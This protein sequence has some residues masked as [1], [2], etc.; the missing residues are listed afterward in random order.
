MK[1]SKRKQA[2]QA[3]PHQDFIRKFLLD[4]FPHALGTDS[5]HLNHPAAVPAL[6]DKLKARTAKLERPA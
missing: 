5:V 6:L 3:E 4:H 1:S 2:V